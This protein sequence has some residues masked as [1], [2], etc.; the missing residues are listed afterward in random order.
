MRDQTSELSPHRFFHLYSYWQLRGKDN[1]LF[2]L[3]TLRFITF[4]GVLIALISVSA[5]IFGVSNKGLEYGRSLAFTV[6]IVSQMAFVLFVIRRG[7]PITSNKYLLFSVLL[8]LFI[9]FLILTF[10][11][12]RH[13]FGI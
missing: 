4:F 2:D 1:S 5:F 9:Q 8:V 6:M 12:L 7:S 11:P 3:K 13:I 10:A